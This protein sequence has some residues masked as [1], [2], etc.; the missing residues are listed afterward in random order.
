MLGAR[1]LVRGSEGSPFRQ[2]LVS[3]TSF[4]P[5]LPTRKDILLWWHVFEG[6]PGYRRLSEKVAQPNCAK[7]RPPDTPGRGA[8]VRDCSRGF[9]A[10]ALPTVGLDN[11]LS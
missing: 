7:C 4:L 10:L 8:R 5:R 11:S 9:L 1:R 2:C 3:R 6:S